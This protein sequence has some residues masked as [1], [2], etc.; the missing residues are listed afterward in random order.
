MKKRKIRPIALAFAVLI[1][2]MAAFAVRM[3]MHRAPR[4][5]LPETPS[6]GSGAA[7]SEPTQ[8]S[9][10]RVEVTRET[11]QDAIATLT[12]P[13][14]YRC[15]I[16]VERYYEGGSGVSSADV[17]VMDGWTHADVSADGQES[18]HAIVGG[19]R[20]WIWYGEDTQVF[21]AAAVVSADEELGIPTYEEVLRADPSRIAAADY[22]DL[23]GAPCIYVETAEDAYGYAE[24]WWV[25][26]E[27]GLLVAAEKLCAGEVVYRMVE[28][29]LHTG[30]VS[31]SDMTLPD[32]TV[33]PEIRPEQN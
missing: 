21:T 5:V 27:S 20:S 19:G 7:V 8:E 6:S 22:R 11:V 13:D 26:V 1:L 28:T 29:D 3:G 16:T 9:V 17:R 24:R 25:S 12:R 23:D 32:G 15:S 14:N 4:V 2:L 10:R 31:A 18:R 30:A 33:L